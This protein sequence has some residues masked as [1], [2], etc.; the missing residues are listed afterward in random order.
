MELRGS[1]RGVSDASLPKAGLY[2]GRWCVSITSH[3]FARRLLSVHS[4][5]WRPFSVHFCVWRRCHWLRRRRH[6]QHAGGRGIARSS[7]KGSCV[8]REQG[9]SSV[10]RATGRC[11]SSSNSWRASV[12]TPTTRLCCCL[13]TSS[14]AARRLLLQ[15]PILQTPARRDLFSSFFCQ[16]LLYGVLLRARDTCVVQRGH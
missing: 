4:T 5:K 3:F 12:T 16:Q 13:R 9:C 14:S 8:W 11:S 10:S 15:R 6:P 7:R 2:S 1:P